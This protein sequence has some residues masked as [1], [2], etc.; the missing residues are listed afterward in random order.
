MDYD[1]SAHFKV[2]SYLHHKGEQFTNRFDAN[3]FLYLTKAIDYFNLQQ[4]CPSLE[5]ALLP[6]KM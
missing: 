5:D 3:S 4:D 2:E 1:F 6:A